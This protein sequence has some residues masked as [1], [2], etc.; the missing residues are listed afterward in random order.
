MLCKIF[1]SDNTFHLENAINK[2]LNSYPANMK[3]NIKHMTQSENVILKNNDIYN[4]I[5]ITIIY[6]VIEEKEEWKPVDPEKQLR[7]VKEVI[8]LHTKKDDYLIKE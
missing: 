2:W 8:D 7:N 5:T 3:I 4:Y 1:T 6:E